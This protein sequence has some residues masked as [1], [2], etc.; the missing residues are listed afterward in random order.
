MGL[1]VFLGFALSVTGAATYGWWY[2]DPYQRFA[3]LDHLSSA[4]LLLIGDSITAAA[5]RMAVGPVTN[6]GV[7]GATTARVLANQDAI[8][9]GTRPAFVFLMIGANDAVDVQLADLSLPPLRRLLR[10][11][12]TRLPD[13]RVVLV[14]CPPA[15]AGL[16]DP[17]H[18]YLRARQRWLAVEEHVEVLD[19]WADLADEGGRLRPE[20]TT[21][22]LHWTDAAYAVYER[23]I[24]RVMR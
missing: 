22:G 15:R 2:D 18:R 3:V 7:D 12:R 23:A 4:P 17:Y 9:L 5:G 11:I 21:D 14:S 19:L 13:A 10:V 1:G 16:R 8:G 20:F 6:R 24:L